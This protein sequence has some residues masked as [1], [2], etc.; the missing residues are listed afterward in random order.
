MAR[1]LNTVLSAKFYDT[2]LPHTRIIGE[3]VL[4][5]QRCISAVQVGNEEA[6]DQLL[7]AGADLFASSTA[8]P[9]SK[10][11][12]QLELSQQDC[13][14]EEELEKSTLDELTTWENMGKD[15]RN[16]CILQPGKGIEISSKLLFNAGV[17]ISATTCHK[18]TALHYAAI[19]KHEDVC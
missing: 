2:P 9:E 14:A 4:Y 16:R 17:D 11:R 10:A 1:R 7:Q 12:R 13:K 18:R 5:R 15:S 6:V 19:G 3:T 8:R